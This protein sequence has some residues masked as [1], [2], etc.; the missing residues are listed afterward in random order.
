M[1]LL[2]ALLLAAPPANLRHQAEPGLSAIRAEALSA[3]MRFL[4]DDLLEGRD[5][6][7]RGHAVAARY[8]AA[9]LQALGYQP[10]G[11]RGSWL[12]TVP[13]IGM[14]VVPDKCVLELNGTP[15]KYPDE[16]LFFPRAGAAE[17]DV[18]GELVFAGY[19]VSAPLYGYDDL[20]QDLRGKI[21]VVLYGA[22]RSDRQDFFPTAANAVYSDHAVKT[23]VLAQ[24]GAVGMIL[25]GTPEIEAHLPWS[26]TVLNFGFERMV[27]REGEK[28]GS[29]YALPAA[30]M[31]TSGLQRLLAGSGHTAE[32]IFAGGPPGKLKPFPLFA[33]ARLRVGARLREF[34]SENVAGVL[35]GGDRAGEYVAVSAHLDHLGIGQPIDGD[36]IYN[37]A[38]DNAS[39]VS[40]AIEVARA[41]AALPRRPARSILVLG[42]TAEEK[43]LQGSDYFARHPTVPP[44]SI[45]ADVN[46]DSMKGL[47][48]EPHDIVPIGAEHS[49]LSEAVRAAAK[50]QGLKISPDPQ[51]EQ[52]FFIRADQYRFVQQGIPAVF[53][54]VGWQDARGSV[55]KAKAYDEWW[56]KNRYH[57][58]SDEWDPAMDFESMA[59][60]ART[61][62]LIALAIALDPSVP[63]WNDGDVFG[64]L[65]PRPAASR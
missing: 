49:T 59:K 32:E 55:E 11:E 9:Q 47:H 58:P 1:H 62:F 7:S 61:N 8:L 28:P 41:F 65:F 14:T 53:P 45:V 39:G 44:G 27:W 57:K 31:P 19:G 13:F 16:V 50:A 21:A 3:H 63:R 36:S 35:R 60:E 6:G 20:P 38:V 46:L 12:Q 43:Y 40:A 33:R 56:T 52:V 29:G 26:F 4:A 18:S 23:R 51:P 54:R 30:W 24:R 22:P 15:L 42:F 34:V 17:D 48:R 5:T 10:A 64:K 37:G 2:L 25:V